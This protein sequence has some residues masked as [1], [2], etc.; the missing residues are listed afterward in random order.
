MLVAVSLCPV[1]QVGL[2]YV[3]QAAL[4]G[5]RWCR[6]AHLLFPLCRVEP[7]LPDLLRGRVGLAPDDG[8]ANHL[9]FSEFEAGAVLVVVVNFDADTFRFELGCDFFGHY[10]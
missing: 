9:I 5:L 3:E 8:D 10:R 2:I 4:Y 6:V 1:E 7:P